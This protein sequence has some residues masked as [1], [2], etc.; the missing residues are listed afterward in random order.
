MW[1]EMKMLDWE[2]LKERYL[3]NNMSTTKIGENFSVIVAG[4][5]LY[6]DLP[7]G[8]QTV[9]RKCLEKAVDLLN[10]GETISGPADYRN[11]VCDERPAYAWAILRDM[12]FIK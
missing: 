2:K 7:S 11:K 3:K 1:K 4:N 10:K 5:T 12:G 6:I 8:K 9:S